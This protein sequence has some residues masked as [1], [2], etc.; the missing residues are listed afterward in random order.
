MSEQKDEKSVVLD[1]EVQKVSL[2]SNPANGSEWMLFK[3]EDQDNEKIEKAQHAVHEPSF[4]G[5]NEKT[6][7]WSSLSMEDFDTDDLS[8]IDDHFVVSK[9][10]FPPENFGDLSLE[11]VDPD[12]NLD[13]DGLESAH[14]TVSQVD[15]LPDNDVDE[16]RNIIEGLAEKNF[17]N[18]S[19]NFLDDEQDMENAQDGD[20][21]NM[22]KEQTEQEESDNSFS[23]GGSDIM[24]DQTDKEVKDSEEEDVAKESSSDDQQEIPEE[25]QEK[26][27]KY[28]ELESKLEK[29]REQRLLK[30]YQETARKEYEDVSKS[31]DELGPLLKEIDENLSD[32]SADEVKSLIKAQAEQIQKGELFEEQGS[33]AQGEVGQGDELE[34]RAEELMKE[35][36][37]VDTKEKARA[38]AVR[39]DP[40]LIR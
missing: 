27:E 12:G 29:E 19:I 30:E 39:Q 33:S 35:R 37:D 6:G 17:D 22:D 3:S 1:A 38:E 9:V 28:D 26:L 32:E 34:K 40:S 5:T 24:A 14:Q 18:E 31:A 8:E 10:G 11:I 21:E 16:A 25:I 20:E 15:G 23:E 2:V 36:D 4:S 13:P 7:Q